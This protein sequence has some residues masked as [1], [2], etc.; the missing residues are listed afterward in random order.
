MIPL[1]LQGALWRE[2]GRLSPHGIQGIVDSYCQIL[3][4]I[5][6]YRPTNFSPVINHVAR[7]PRNQTVRLKCPSS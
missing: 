4:Q 2:L 1:R 6:L 7:L 5:Q 3:P